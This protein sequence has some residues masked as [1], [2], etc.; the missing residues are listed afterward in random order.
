MV[1]DAR[2]ITLRTLLKHCEGVKEWA[3]DHGYGDGLELKDDYCVSFY[4][5]TFE[6]KPCYYI[7]WSSIESVWL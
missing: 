5:S 4:K 7:D 1:D 2:Q 6:G 3:I